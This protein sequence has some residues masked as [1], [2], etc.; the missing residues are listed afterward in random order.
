MA[1][2]Q[3]VFVGNYDMALFAACDRQGK[4]RI[5]WVDVNKGEARIGKKLFELAKGEN[6]ESQANML[7]LTAGALQAKLKNEKES[8]NVLLVFTDKVA[9]RFF[10]IQKEMKTA[11]TLEEVVQE[12][13][14]NWM[15]EMWQTAIEDMVTA[16]AGALEAGHL[17][18]AVKASELT[19]ARLEG[20]ETAEADPFADEETEDVEVEDGTKLY[21]EKG[22]IKGV[23]VGEEV[24]P[25]GADAKVVGDRFATGTFTVVN[26]GTEEEPVLAINRW[27]NTQ[28]EKVPA[29]YADLMAVNHALWDSLPKRERIKVSMEA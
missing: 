19:F 4:A 3:N 2:A 7:S 28:E 5:A 10:E 18:G 22:I 8:R 29:I 24:I 20:I 27:E 14:K 1:K 21:I 16:Y 23:V 12:C 6:S 9:P 15:P 11:E 26:R 17:V 13:T 25:C